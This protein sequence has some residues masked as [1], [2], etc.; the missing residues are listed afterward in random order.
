MWAK[1]GFETPLGVVPVDIELAQALIDADPRI[2][3]D[4][5][6]HEA[7]HVIEIELPFLQRACPDCKVVPVLMGDDHPETVE[8]L[9]GALLTALPGERAVVIASSDLSH[10]PSYEDA[11]MVDGATLSAVEIGDPALLRENIAQM[12]T[13]GVPNLVTCACGSG[14]ILVAMHVARGLGADTFSVLHYANSGDSPYGEAGRVV[15]YGAV[16]LWRYEAPALTE[17]HREEL[18]WLARS[19]IKAHLTTGNIPIYDTQDPVLARRSG[20]FVT[21]LKEGELR[22]CV[23]HLQADAPLYAVVQQMA[24]AAA[25]DERFDPVTADELSE[26]TIEISVLTPQRRLTD[27]DQIELGTHGL[28]IRKGAS[29]G[30]FLPQ[31]PLEEGWDRQATLE[32]LCLKA[33]LSLDCWRE[34]A[35]LYTFEAIAFPEK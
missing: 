33:G 4:P 2:T 34:D 31:V 27:L 35:W 6:A 12:M 23:G 8:A 17:A 24:V 14:P 3:F 15:G 13:A 20:A 28:V 10:Y 26:L 16:M 25:Q 7:E 19:A 9:A 30:V 11:M 22:G 18:L 32:Q 29:Q 5:A 21:L 1:G